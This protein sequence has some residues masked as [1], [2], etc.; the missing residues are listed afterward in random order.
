MT[1]CFNWVITK[2]LGKPTKLNS[3]YCPLFLQCL[4]CLQDRLEDCNLVL[5]IF[6]RY[7]TISLKDLILEF[8]TQLV[9]FN[10][11]VVELF[12]KLLLVVHPSLFGNSERFL[13]AFSWMFFRTDCT[14][15]S[16]KSLPLLI[17]RRRCFSFSQFTVSTKSKVRN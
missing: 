17:K 1:F 6:N 9:V 4:L 13:I 12:W 5:V 7:I 15:S 2:V 8:A 3:L 16:T 11:T 10:L 14:A